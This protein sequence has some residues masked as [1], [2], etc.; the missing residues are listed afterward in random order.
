MG[1]GAVNFASRFI[2][3]GFFVEGVFLGVF[4][5]WDFFACDRSFNFKD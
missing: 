5:V 4:G 1:V 3:R 2:H